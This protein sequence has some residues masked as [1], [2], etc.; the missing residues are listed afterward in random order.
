MSC[1][2][3]DSRLNDLVDGTLSASEH[4]AVLEHLRGCAECRAEEARLRALLAA[5]AA[6]PR[7][8][9]PERDLWPTIAARIGG[10]S[11]VAGN[12]APLG[13]G[14]RVGRDLLAAAAS[15]VIVA[16]VVLVVSQGRR[17]GS[18]SEWRK[19]PSGTVRLAGFE[20]D[21]V[22]GS[23][24]K[25]RQ[26]LV[27]LIDARRSALT[28]DTIKV[29]DENLRVIDTAVERIETA[30]KLDPGNRELTTLLVATYRQEVDLLRRVNQLASKV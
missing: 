7:E 19:A 8:V 28:P 27:S 1:Q 11:V 12:F 6:L 21:S 30:L 25:A 23:F 22:R 14:W 13:R 26:E 9:V 17:V 5:A 24:T 2:D 15:V 20:L 4:R 18:D 3:M 10:G 16:A 29:V